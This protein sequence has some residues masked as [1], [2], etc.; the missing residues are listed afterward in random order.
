MLGGCADSPFLG[1]FYWNH[2]G[3]G[4]F[5]ESEG[6]NLLWSVADAA[7]KS[8][9]RR[10]WGLGGEVVGMVFVCVCVVVCVCVCVCACV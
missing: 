8:G 3:R 4:D 6:S 2:R 1:V 7:P 10:R 5:W 9:G